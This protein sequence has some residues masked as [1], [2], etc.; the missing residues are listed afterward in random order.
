M[1][2]I[3]KSLLIHKATLQKSNDNSAWGTTTEDNPLTL[4]SCIRIDPSSS[5]VT[6][7]TNKQLQLTAMLFYDCKNSLPKGQIFCEEDKITFNNKEYT[8]QSVAEL[9]DEKKLHHYEI[10]LI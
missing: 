5:I 9:Y 4:L 7:K 1:L 3:P 6:T 10:G 2:P 8:I